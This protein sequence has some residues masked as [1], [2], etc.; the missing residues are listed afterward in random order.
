MLVILSDLHLNDGTTGTLLAPG[1]MD[2]LSERLCDMAWRAS[3]RAD[4]T[5]QPIE[6]ID[7]VLLGDVLDII[8]SQ[9]W[10]KGD[11]RPWSNIQSPTVS[12]TVGT[13]V[14]EILRRNIEAVRTLRSLATEATI[15]L[16]PATSHGKPVPDAEELPVPVYTHY[17][18]GNCDWPLHIRGAAY[19]VIRHKVTHHLGLVTPHNRP[20]AHDASENE[21][22]LDTLRRHRVLARHGDIF[23]PLSFAD[24]RDASSLSDVIAIE[25]VAKF[26]AHIEQQMATELP[27]AT[28]TALRE[29]DQIRPV[30]LVPAWMESTLDRTTTSAAVRNSVKRVWDYMVEQ[31]LHLEI[32]RKHSSNSPVD[33]ID[34]LAA[35][36]KFGC[37]D[38]HDWT[39]RTLAW[40]TGL[41]GATSCSYAGH[42]MAEADF[43]NRRARHIVYGHTHAYEVIPLD[44][45]HADGYVL[46]Q[47]YFNAGTWRRTYQPTQIKS[48]CRE[49]IAN[50]CFSLLTFYQGDERRGRSH[51]T[52]CGTLAPGIV[53]PQARQF[54]TSAAS[55][56]AAPQFATARG[57]TEARSY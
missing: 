11:A 9:R 36:L 47:T 31:L 3:W 10:L 6:Q 33:L 23:D 26:L 34:G 44:A 49:F 40:L 14:D 48:G 1:I 55:S 13:I 12:D 17:M 15:S 51:E 28:A 19:D 37:R 43:R 45:S 50:D 4:G 42:A 39:G 16:P 41:R 27:T 35:A 24:D 29:I 22:L 30:L 52:W 21:E 2:L 54:S 53:Q 46:N 25:L 38:S 18:V 32:V 7:L 57:R 5:Y 56:I 8:G 20:F